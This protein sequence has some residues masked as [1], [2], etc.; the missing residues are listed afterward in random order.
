MCRYNMICQKYKNWV[1]GRYFFYRL[2]KIIQ[3]KL[4]MAHATRIL[5]EK[6]T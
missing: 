5:I 4:F 1:L 6:F 2:F 3:V